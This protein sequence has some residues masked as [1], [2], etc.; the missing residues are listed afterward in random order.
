[1]SKRAATAPRPD[2]ITSHASPPSYTLRIPPTA[3]SSDP[4]FEPVVRLPLPASRDRIRVVELLATGSSGGA[5]E[6][7][8]NL[9][10]RLDRARYDVS[11]LSLS[12]GPAVRRLERT[13]ISV[14]ALDEMDDEAAI[15]A[16]AAHLAAVKA[17]D[18]HNHM[19]RAEVVGTQAAWRIAATGRRRTF[20]V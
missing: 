2:L 20:V 12:N 3:L 16:V 10:T 4:C 19:N 9:V 6:H 18:V 14:C 11:V 13:G 17:D 7:V 5:Q 1:M 15:E 8:Y